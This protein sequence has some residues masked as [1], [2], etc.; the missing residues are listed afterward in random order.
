MVAVE[1]NKAKSPSPD[2]ILRRD[3][4]FLRTAVP[5]EWDSN[6]E[7]DAEEGDRK[8]PDV[9]KDD[10]ASRRARMNQFKPG[11][12]HHFLPSSC[13]SKDR[14]KWE[15]IRL[16]SQHAVLERMEKM[17]QE[18]RRCERRMGVSWWSEKLCWL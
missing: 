5:H 18:K 3:N 6:E 8:V 15:G 13:S 10:L 11:V 7:D 1:A 4:D 14:E 17:E 9:Q 12:A 16:A 2:I